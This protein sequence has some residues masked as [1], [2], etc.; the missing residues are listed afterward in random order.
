M[1][2]ARM[3]IITA[4]DPGA[5]RYDVLGDIHGCYDELSAIL[6]MAG[7]IIDDIPTGDETYGA[8]HPD[9][10][11][12]IFAGDLTDRGPYS[13]LVLRLAMGMIARGT[14]LWVRGNHDDKL[15]R[16]LKGNPVKVSGG[17]AITLS[18]IESWSAERTA[19]LTALMG[20]LPYQIRLPM[21]DNHPRSGDGF[22]T[23]VHGAAPSHHLD[24]DNKNARNR[25][26]YGYPDGD[27]RQDG[28]LSRQDWA[29]SYRGTRWVMHGHEPFLKPYV[30][31]NVIG[32]DTGCVFGNAMTLYRADACT[33]LSVSAPRDYSGKGRTL[34]TAPARKED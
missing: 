14:A 8:F 19:D 9:G 26:I 33:F 11:L 17:L 7:W 25:S 18:Q 27:V 2:Q 21:P 3:N 12:L 16:Y 4:T 29:E 22:M 15:S 6:V 28:T 13:D 5:A 31:N 23:V 10:R 34:Q 1:Q 32:L 30:K 24:Q 20:N